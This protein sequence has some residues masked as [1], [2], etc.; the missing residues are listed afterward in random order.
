M[1]LCGALSDWMDRDLCGGLQSFAS[2]PLGPGSELRQ[3]DGLDPEFV[4]NHD[5]DS[6]GTPSDFLS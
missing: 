3:T 4:G 5:C 6:F 2:P 1:D